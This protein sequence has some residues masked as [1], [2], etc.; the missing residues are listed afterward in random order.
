M[1]KVSRS[2]VRSSVSSDADRPDLRAFHDAVVHDNVSSVQQLLASGLCPNACIT[3]DLLSYNQCDGYSLLYLASVYNR[4]EIASLLLRAGADPSRENEEDDSVFNSMRW[5]ANPYAYAVINQNLVLLKTLLRD[6]LQGYELEC[7]GQSLPFGLFREFHNDDMVLKVIIKSASEQGGSFNN[8]FRPKLGDLLQKAAQNKSADLCQYLFERFGVHRSLIA[9]LDHTPEG[10]ERINAPVFSYLVELHG[11]K[12]CFANELLV[13]GSLRYAHKG[14]LNALLGYLYEVYGDNR[15][16]WE[17]LIRWKWRGG[18]TTQDISYVEYIIGKCRDGNKR[19]IVSLL[20]W[21][22]FNVLNERSVPQERRVDS[23]FHGRSD[24]RS[25]PSRRFTP[26][27]SPLLSCLMYMDA[28]RFT[29]VTLLT[30]LYPRCAHGSWFN[31]KYDPVGD[32]LAPTDNSPGNLHEQLRQ[33]PLLQALCRS[34]IFYA[35]GIN[36]LPKAERLPLPR[37]LKDFVQ[38]RDLFDSFI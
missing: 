16:W 31:E 28:H 35:L 4:L 12:N 20:R 30:Q 23:V 33:V 32:V 22:I 24:E 19:Q 21:G 7:D 34:V 6:E 25:V 27:E 18:I 26:S 13:Q 10:T 3:A 8:P 36:P 29:S 2:R 37:R 9:F 17:E 15:Q 11:V 38:C 14:I 5:R 1:Q